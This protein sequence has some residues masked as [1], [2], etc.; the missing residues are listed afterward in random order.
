LATQLSLY[1]DALGHIGE[2]QLASLSENV[3]PRRV[4]DLVWPGARNYCL[5]HAHWKF[6]QRT[7]A[8][9]YSPSVTPAFGY[10]RAFEKPTDL[11]KLSKLCAD[12]F[13]QLPLTQVVEENGF[14]FA[15]ID[16][17]Y[18]SYVSNDTAYGYDYSLWPETFSLFVSLYLALRIAPRVAPTKDVRIIT[19]QY[20]R[21]KE[22]AQAK[23]AMQGPTQFLPAGSWVQSRM[24]GYRGDRG[25]R[26]T[27]Y[28]G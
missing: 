4:L 21:A 2:R 3:E 12:E 14:W 15:N 25:F 5:E 19:N 1:N 9:S 16:T 13:F 26:N 22:D 11:V 23:D 27:L 7:S 24:G 8:I 6:A 17:L 10:N 20:E 18:V 28:G